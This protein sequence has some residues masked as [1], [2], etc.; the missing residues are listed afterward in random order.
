MRDQALIQVDESKCSEVN[1]CFGVTE[2][3]GVKYCRGCGNC[4]PS[5]DMPDTHTSEKHIAKYT[6]D[7]TPTQRPEWKDRMLHTFLG[8]H[9]D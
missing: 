3:D 6:T 4:V 7:E 1:N 9:H 2:K 5:Q 8:G